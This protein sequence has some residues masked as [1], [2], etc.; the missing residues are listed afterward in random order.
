VPLSWTDGL[1]VTVTK[2]FVFRRGSYQIGLEYAIANASA[3]P[4]VFQPYAQLLRHNTPVERSMFDVESYS[5]RVP[6]L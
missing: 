6:L 2:T 5:F 1:G 3:T 4:W